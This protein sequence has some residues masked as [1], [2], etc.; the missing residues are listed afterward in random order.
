MLCLVILSSSAH[1][2]VHTVAVAER[3]ERADVSYDIVSKI[4]SRQGERTIN[5][6]ARHTRD[7]LA[8]VKQ[9]IVG[10]FFS[11]SFEC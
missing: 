5:S 10:F 11:Y 1:R 7:S 8:R 6:F 3:G 2:H 9:T 4:A